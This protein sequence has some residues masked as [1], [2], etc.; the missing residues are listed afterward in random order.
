[1]MM[2]RS[3]LRVAAAVAT[4]VNITGGMEVKAM[5]LKPN[6]IQMNGPLSLNLCV[7]EDFCECLRD[8]RKMK[9]ASMM[10]E[11]TTMKTDKLQ[12]AINTCNDSYALQVWIDRHNKAGDAKRNDKKEQ[13]RLDR[14]QSEKQRKEARQKAELQDNIDN[15]LGAPA[16]AAKFLTRVT[17]N[18]VAGLFGLVESGVQFVGEPHMSRFAKDATWLNR[19]ARSDAAWRV[20][21][22]EKHGTNNRSQSS[23]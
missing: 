21:L 19:D 18:G 11:Y 22:K 8:L 1:M 10:L 16:A 7:R 17:G 9:Y 5:K 14:E 13:E 20:Y 15:V 3:C 4:A 2:M 6:K 12:T 23:K